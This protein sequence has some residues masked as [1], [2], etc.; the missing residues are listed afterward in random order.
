MLRA[1]LLCVIWK[2]DVGAFFPFSSLLLAPP[3]CPRDTTNLLCRR[4]HDCGS[5]GGAQSPNNGTTYKSSV[6]TVR[7]AISYFSVS[8]AQCPVLNPGEG[9]LLPHRRTP[10]MP[11]NRWRVFDDIWT[12]ELLNARPSIYPT[13]DQVWKCEMSCKV[14]SCHRSLKPRHS[15]QYSDA[16]CVISV[17]MFLAR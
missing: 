8:T 17:V 14:V 5:L 13:Q 1:M 4:S 11:L 12:D 15:N 2:T 7:C 9:V 3:G 16:Y 10:E 6:S